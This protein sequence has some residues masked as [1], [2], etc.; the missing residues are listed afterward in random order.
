MLIV[1]DLLFWLAV[2]LAEVVGTIAGFGSATVL[3]PV[4]LLFMDF[5][6]ALVL[7]AL[8]HLF[9]SV[10]RGAFFRKK[11]SW[12]ITSYFGFVGIFGA[13]VGALLVTHADQAILQLGLGIFL[14]GYGFFVFFKPAFKLKQTGGNLLIGGLSSGFLAGIIGTGGALRTAFLTA[15]RIPKAQYIG[16]SAAIAIAVD[17]IRIPVYL[18]DGLLPAD[19][20]WTL[21]LLF[22]LAVGGAYVGKK[23]ADKI[24]PLL[25]SRIILAA[26]I[27]AGVKLVL[28]YFG[29]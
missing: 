24:P 6:T 21:P 1:M 29:A 26:L 4:A 20:Y 27:L 25:F 11:I 2:F 9:G 15:F 3:L 14:I 17:G 12:K 13:L 8:V 5:K 18:R 10:G 7:T 16:T 22:V 19:Y 23:L 28:D